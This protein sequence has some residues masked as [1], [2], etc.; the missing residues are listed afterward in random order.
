[1]ET[2][3]WK[4]RIAFLWVFMPVADLVHSLLVAWT[5]GGLEKMVSRVEAGGSGWLLFEALFSLIPLWLAFMTLIIKDS[6]N[7]WLNVPFGVVFTI[8]NIFHFFQCGV[9]LLQGGPVT[10]ITAHHVL[11]VGSTVIAAVMIAW[12]AG[13]GYK[14]EA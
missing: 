8:L 13:R 4:V 10:Q 5:P 1:M 2:L 11:L 3:S 7:R 12:Y 9:P 14:Q 6:I